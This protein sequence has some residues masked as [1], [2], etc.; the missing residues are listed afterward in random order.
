MTELFITTNS[1][2]FNVQIFDICGNMLVNQTITSRSYYSGC[3][4]AGC[5][6]LKIIVTNLSSDNI[7][8]IYRTINVS[9]VGC[10]EYRTNFVFNR[11]EQP[12]TG[13]LQTFR[14]TDENY[15]FDIP[16]AVLNFA[17]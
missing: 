1:T 11:I 2:R 8:R 3:V 13:S 10:G 12:S 5:G 7:Q 14:L 15:G 6:E 9:N 16:Y 17:Q 4:Y